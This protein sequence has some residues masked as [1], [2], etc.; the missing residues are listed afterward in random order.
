MMASLKPTKRPLCGARAH[1]K[2]QLT[3]AGHKTC[4][5]C[6]VFSRDGVPVEVRFWSHVKKGDRCWIWT[7]AV[8]NGYGRFGFQKRTR[9][10]HHVSWI[11]SGRKAPNWN[12]RE[13]IDHKCDNKLCVRVGHLRILS[14]AKNVSRANK[15]PFCKRGHPMKGENL[16]FYGED[17]HRKRRC[18]ACMVL[19]RRGSVLPK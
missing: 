18:R 15:K 13:T 6:G 1:H 9:W 3:D 19:R 11:L 16:Y 2:M 8:T 7:G 17:L 10:V 5:R 12:L 14:L 4:V